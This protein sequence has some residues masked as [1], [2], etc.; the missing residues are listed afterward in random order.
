MWYDP[1]A[2]QSGDGFNTTGWYRLDPGGCQTVFNGD[3]NFNRCWAYYAESTDGATWSG[4]IQAWVS[5]SAF[6][7]CH[8]NECT[9]CRIVG[10]RPLDINNFSDYTVTLVD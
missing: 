5:N 7:L 8:G 4:N 3:I 10:F 2:C 6:T 1:Q 9:P